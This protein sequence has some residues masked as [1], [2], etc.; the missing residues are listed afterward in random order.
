[1]AGG[2]TVEECTAD[3]QAVGC[4]V[5]AATV[6]RRM[7]ELRGAVNAAAVARRSARANG[8][9]VPALTLVITIL[10]EWCEVQADPN[11]ALER[12]LADL[13]AHNRLAAAARLTAAALHVSPP[14]AAQNGAAT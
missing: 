1:M 7:R 14:S 10:R 13:D 11:A 4:K 5:S 3:L 9:E 12:V 8:P 2:K 6:G